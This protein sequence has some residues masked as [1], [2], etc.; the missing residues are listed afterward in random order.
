MVNETD[1]I[2]KIAQKYVRMEFARGRWVIERID[3]AHTRLTYTICADM[4]GNL[5][6]WVVDV[7]LAERPYERMKNLRQFVTLP[8][9]QP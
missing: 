8:K 9:Y 4:G 6:Q 3:D 7:F 5:P 2:G 1:G